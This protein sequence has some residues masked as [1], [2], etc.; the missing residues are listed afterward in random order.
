MP[1]RYPEPF[2]L[3][4]AEAICSGIPVLV[5]DSAFLAE[6]IERL[7]LGLVYKSASI[8]SLT[9]KITEFLGMDKHVLQEMG[10]RCRRV[11]KE[12][13]DNEDVWISQLLS[14]Y[15]EKTISDVGN[16]TVAATV[17]KF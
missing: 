16:Q 17:G 6:E 12:I 3:V 11:G 2:G 9:E 13:F 1:S 5:N 4:V 10:H 14:V 15:Y 7:N 8:S